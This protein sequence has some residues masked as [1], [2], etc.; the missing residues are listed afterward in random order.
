VGA[1]PK[2]QVNA[3]VR[4]LVRS[5]TASSPRLPVCP[6]SS[7]T[8]RAARL[9]DQPSGSGDERA[10][11]RITPAA[12]QSDC[13]VGFGEPAHDGDRGSA[14]AALRPN[15]RT[16]QYDSKVCQLDQARVEIWV[17]WNDSTP[18]LLR[19]SVLQFER[20]PD[21][22]GRFGQH[23][24]VRLAISPGRRPALTDSSTSTRLQ[25]GYLVWRG[26]PAGLQHD[27][28]TRFWRACIILGPIIELLRG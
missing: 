6:A 23:R 1:T 16:V 3:A 14:A 17:Y 24:Q 21:L 5:S 7:W 22:A 15:H 26:R 19:C 8:S 27:R 28:A 20:L 2:D 10:A 9:V 13:P 12:L 25:T 4:L 11:V 18:A